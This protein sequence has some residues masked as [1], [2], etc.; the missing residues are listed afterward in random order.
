MV[1]S[2]KIYY[3]PICPAEKEHY[4]APTETCNMTTFDINTEQWEEIA[5]NRSSWRQELKNGLKK[6]ETRLQQSA[7]EQR[8]RRKHSHSLT[9]AESVFK[10][11][12]LSTK[13]VITNWTVQP[14]QW[15]TRSI[16]YRLWN[17]YYLGVL[18]RYVCV[19]H[20]RCFQAIF[21]GRRKISP[22]PGC[23]S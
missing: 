20:G 14:Q 8:T 4:D 6:G 18:R 23:V 1:E 16:Y 17:A 9:P 2:R 15:L 22:G 19:R 13:T 10:C 21:S 5:V 3:T 12:H 7:G 11:S